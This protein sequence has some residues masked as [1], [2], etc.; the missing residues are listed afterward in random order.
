MYNFIH[1]VVDFTVIVLDLY[2]HVQIWVEASGTVGKIHYIKIHKMQVK[3]VQVG[4]S[5]NN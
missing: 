4:S 1:D 3:H 2:F 5:L